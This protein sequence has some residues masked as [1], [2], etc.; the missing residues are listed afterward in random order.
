[1]HK[2]TVASAPLIDIS[3]ER[4]S[5]LK[6][7]E[8]VGA[9]T[10]GSHRGLLA[11]AT[12]EPGAVQQ[13]HRLNS[14]GQVA[15]LLSGRAEFLTPD[16]IVAIGPGDTIYAKKG[17]W[18]GFRNTS[19]EPSVFLFAYSPTPEYAKMGY[20]PFEGDVPS[21]QKSFDT[22]NG[23]RLSDLQTDTEVDGYVGLGVYWLAVAE[24]V[25][26]KDFLLGASTF[27]PGGLHAHHRHPG[28]DEYLFILEG[29]GEH[30]TVDGAIQLNAGELAY[31]PANEFHGYQ[32]REG[33]FTKTIFG[34]FG[35]SNLEEAGNDVMEVKS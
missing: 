16:G 31:I 4:N 22:L 34:Y 7:Q 24:T 1:M 26:T 8:L 17:E 19:E 15:Y 5:G 18:H 32:N 11:L 6:L 2:I 28:G 12:F 9:G 35:P 27:E 23:C 10:V 33:I 3:A 29:G 14:A 25:G 13:V 21:T 30:L 20:E